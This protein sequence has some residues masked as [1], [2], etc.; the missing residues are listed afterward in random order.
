MINFQRQKKRH[1][2]NRK[3]MTVSFLLKKERSVNLLKGLLRAPPTPHPGQITLYPLLP[4]PSMDREHS[5][6]W[7]QDTGA[8]STERER[9][10]GEKD[11]ERH[12]STSDSS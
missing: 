6:H 5:L 10:D 2:K 12:N 3:K 4:L 1:I 8:T 9:R 11:K 7:L